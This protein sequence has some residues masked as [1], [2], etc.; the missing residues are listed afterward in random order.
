ML[1]AIKIFL[2]SFIGQMPCT[3]DGHGI[4]LNRFP[5][6]E[7]KTLQIKKDSSVFIKLKSLST[8]GYVW[9]YSIEDSSVVIVEKKGSEFPATHP[10]RV[11]DSGMEVFAVKGLKSRLDVLLIVVDDGQIYFGLEINN[12]RLDELARNVGHGLAFK[13]CIEGHK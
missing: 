10:K 12:G 11:G 3:V 8:S 1:L 13:Q 6:M 9:N 2:L 7:M 4:C 5:K